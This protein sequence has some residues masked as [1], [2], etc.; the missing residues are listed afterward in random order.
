VHSVTRL[1][2]PFDPVSP[3]LFGPIFR[4]KRGQLFLPAG[5]S[6]QFYA[7][8]TG[9][10]DDRVRW[11]IEGDSSLGTINRSG[12]Y[13]APDRLTTP[14]T[15][16]I[17]A[18]CESDLSKSALTS[19]VIPP[20]V[21]RAEPR[22]IQVLAGGTAVVKA[23]VDNTENVGVEWRIEG[24]NNGRM[25]ESG[26]YIAP[27]GMATPRTINLTA[28]SV[29]DPTKE[30]SVTIAVPAVE[31]H[32]SRTTVDLKA[33]ET[34]KFSA[35]VR[36][37]ANESIVWRVEGDGNKGEISE[38]GIFRAPAR[39]RESKTVRVIAASAADPGKYVVA[40]VRIRP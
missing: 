3:I 27:S 37:A 13:T 17:R 1:Y 6:Y 33:G 28:V 9:T 23:T 26:T 19:L 2:L 12:L 16:V 4:S 20:I 7:R 22:T 40:A 10:A 38:S 39:I 24:R 21:V 35:K 5:G 30:A 18:T 11:T 8:V 36:N 14:S 31:I 34:F 15:V 25:T 29:A 32:L